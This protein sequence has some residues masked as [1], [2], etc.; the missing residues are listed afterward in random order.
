MGRFRRVTFPSIIAAV[1]ALAGLL[2]LA[3]GL[4]PLFKAAAYFQLDK[5]PEALR[6][7]PAQR[8]SGVMS[9]FLGVLLIALAKGLYER[10]RRSWGWAVVLLTL[11]MANNLWRATTPQTVL[12][13]GTAIVGLILFHRRFD[14]RAETKIVYGQI[15]GLVTVLFALSYGTVG[16][17]LM[18]AQFNGIE[19]WTD[20][21]YF[22][23][24]T[25][26]TLGYG[27][28][29][30]VT[31]DAK[32]FVISM[33]VVGVGSFITALALV[34][35]PLVETHMKGVLRLMSRFQNLTNHVVIC[36]Y[37]NVS[38]SIMDELREQNVPFLI[39]EDRPD[40]VGHL[41]DRGQDVVVADATT[42]EAL[43]QANVKKA[44]AVIAAFDNDSVNTMIALT[45]DEHRR[46][47]KGCRFRIIVRV[48]E[49]GN[50]EKVRHVGADE[51]ISPSTLGGRLMARK[52]V[53]REGD[54]TS[55]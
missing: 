28:M 46:S 9:I 32:I 5:V 19:T 12:L 8:V 10:R 18:R 2:N 45:A 39:V 37:S 30:P 17:Y 33:I 53:T 34:A 24:V 49:E 27:D 3:T 51:V 44:L 14:V 54:S 55:P 43:V 21:F 42:R 15:F 47:E 48:E 38:D 23:F 31:D 4:V 35:G 11:L 13:S 6:L 16:T 50:I 29:L 52:A 20:S 36:G 26:S 41:R 1:L 25:Y 22:T 40:L 7:S